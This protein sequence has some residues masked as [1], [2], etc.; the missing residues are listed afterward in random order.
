ME[1]ERAHSHNLLQH[2]VMNVL[3]I[4][5]VVNLLLCLTWKLN[6]I[7]VCVYRKKTDYIQGLVLLVVS[8]IHWESWEYPPWIR[9]ALGY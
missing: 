9:R 5:I 4:I 1:R 7:T 2:T 8:G 6:F 3:F